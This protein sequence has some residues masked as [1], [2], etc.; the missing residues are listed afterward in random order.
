MCR[1]KHTLTND[2]WRVDETYVKVEG[3]WMCMYQAVD[4][5]GNTMKFIL[6]PTRD[7]VSAKRFFG[8][9]VRARHTTPPGVVNVDGNLAC[10]R[11]VG[12]LKK[13][14][15]L[16]SDCKLRP[17]KYL[18]NLIE[19]D[20]RFIC[21]APTQGWGSGHSTRH[22][23]HFKAMRQRVYCVRVG[24]KEQPGATLGARSGSYPQHSG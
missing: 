23:E 1:A 2:S 21:G 20:H 4:S 18:N 10:P 8:K 17:I 6:S 3:E 22:G 11:A 24:S 19:Q 14:G 7:A 5:D 13:K 12:K 15:T 9:A 16:P